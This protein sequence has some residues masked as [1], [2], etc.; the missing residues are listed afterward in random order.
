MT[1]A[2]PARKPYRKAPPQHRESR[3]GLPAAPPPPAP[4]GDISQVNQHFLCSAPLPQLRLR[5]PHAAVPPSP[6]PLS[7]SE[8]DISSLSSLDRCIPPPPLFKSHSHRSRTRT[9]AVGI[10]ASD[11]HSNR[12]PSAH[13]KIFPTGDPKRKQANSQALTANRRML[14][15][16]LLADNRTATSSS[17]PRSIL[18]Q[19]PFPDVEHTY[20][21][22]RKSK[23]VEVLDESEGQGH[24]ARSLDR[25]SRRSSTLPP[26]CGADWNWRIEVLEEKVRFSSFLDEITCQVLSPAH[27][28]L[29]GKLPPQEL[30]GISRAHRK[31]R[32]VADRTR[33]WDNWVADLQQTESVF[34]AQPEGGGAQVTPQE[35]S[36][37]TERRGAKEEWLGGCREVKMEVQNKEEPQRHR[38]SNL[39]LLS[40]IKV[41]GV[42]AGLN[43]FNICIYV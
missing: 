22:I 8:P 36:D 1:S 29:F 30:G 17:S 37:I 42:W 11:R 31:H 21:V 40:C 23:S 19:P 4:H 39:L 25:G 13:R 7:D 26:P 35:E 43:N 9:T 3:H 24:A 5:H 14:A 32:A 41:G 18:K 6:L 10:T 38:D 15:K 12:S 34:P 16:N 27:L 28:T 20:D 2:A 33:R